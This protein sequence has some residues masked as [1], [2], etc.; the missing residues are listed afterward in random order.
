VTNGIPDTVP[1]TNSAVA[2]SNGLFSV[3]LDFGAGLFTGNNYWLDI[4]VRAVGLTNF[5]PLLPRQPLLP[6]PYA[7]FAT[8]ASNVLGTLSATQLTGTVPSA[9]IAGTYSGTVNFPN[10][11]NMFAGT[12]TGNGTTLTKLDA[13]QLTLGTVA[14]ARLSTNI[15]LLN[16][17][18]TFTGGNTFTSSNFFNGANNFTNR[19]NNFTGSFFGNGLV[20]WI[21]VSGPLVQAVPD[22]G[23]LLT[24]TLFTTVA[25]PVTPSLYVGDIVRIA[26]AGPGGWRALANTNQSFLGNFSSYKNSLWLT[27]TVTGTKWYSL[28]AAAS[29]TRIYGTCSTGIFSSTDSGHTWTGPIGGFTGTWYGID[30]SADGNTVYAVATTK[31]IQ[32]SNSGGVSWL[33]VPSITAS[34]C[35]AVACSA[36]G[37]KAIVAVNSGQLFITS[38]SGGSWSAV[39]AAGGGGWT[40]LTYSGDGSTYAAAKG[41]AVYSSAV[42]SGV[43]VAANLTGLV[44][45]S[46]GS[47]LVACANPGGIYTSTNSGTSW[48]A[49]AA[50]TA[51]W[52]CL[53][54]SADCSRLVAG[55]SNGI[56]YAS[57]NF[58]ANWSPLNATNQIWSALASSADGSVLA[59]GS[60]PGTGGTIF[61]S[62]AAQKSTSSTTNGVIVGSQGS[63]VE[64][65]Y[66]GNNQFMPVSSTGSLWVN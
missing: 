14:D 22:T 49:T 48:V 11:T 62:S 51:N 43:S 33:P 16:A 12:F 55:I 18:Q 66:I 24:N 40:A 3:T 61:Y 13:T 39:S 50:P 15:A 21:P 23:Y 19:G 30:T 52:N 28:A 46:D 64:L 31:A 29:G 35:T 57:V 7:I 9:Q 41:N 37:T 42:G 56:I 36:D 54:A 58:G 65:Q 45:S 26:G 4:G 47:K 53:A 17:N 34:N 32:I 8:G 63:A 6:T 5:T 25:M 44:S 1:I 20:G 38:N 60:N 59:G 10:S 2:V 27:A